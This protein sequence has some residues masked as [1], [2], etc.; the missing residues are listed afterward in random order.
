M[1]LFCVL[2]HKKCFAAEGCNETN[3]FLFSSL[4][5]LKLPPYK[6]TDEM[7]EKLMIVAENGKLGYSFT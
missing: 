5:M 1:E 7:F 4:N 2:L 3:K 6:N